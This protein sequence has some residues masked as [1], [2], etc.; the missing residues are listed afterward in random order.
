MWFDQYLVNVIVICRS[1]HRKRKQHN[2]NPLCP[3]LN[4]KE[5]KRYIFFLKTSTSTYIKVRQ[6]QQQQQKK[7]NRREKKMSIMDMPSI[8]I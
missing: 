3:V 2:A 4:E 1:V 7:K 8:S 6:Q 5:K